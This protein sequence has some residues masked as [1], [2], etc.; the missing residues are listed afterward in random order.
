[1]K[2]KKNDN[3]IVISGKDKGKKGKVIKALPKLDKVV[4][5]GINVVKKHQKPRQ[6]GKPGQIIEKP[7]PI[8]VSNVKKSSET[9]TKANTKKS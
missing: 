3:I 2:I 8:H 6:A 9:K 7:M 4:V 1:M 5:E